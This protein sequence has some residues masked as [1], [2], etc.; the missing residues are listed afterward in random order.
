MPAMMDEDGSRSFSTTQWS[1]IREAQDSQNPHSKEALQSLCSAYWHPVYFFIRRRGYTAEEAEDLTQG[2]FAELLE[3]NFLGQADRERGRFRTFLLAAVKHYLANEWDR[4]RAQKRGGGYQTL[5]FDFE[6]A[7][8][9]FQPATDLTP[10]KIY[11]E[12]WATN[13]LSRVLTRLQD[14]MEEQGRPERF[15][16]LKV[17]LTGKEPHAPYREVA[18]D[19]GISE[20]AVK[21]AVYRMRRR[22]GQLL[23]EEIRNTVVDDGQV[24]EEIRFL[25]AALKD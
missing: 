13:L 7:E 15:G 19:L 14:E 20:G 8:R 3:K 2:F 6:S 17:F 21:I 24:D 16:R 10:D 1:L 12:R 4:A 9:T 23:R 11:I 25:F 5:S 22:F 18:N